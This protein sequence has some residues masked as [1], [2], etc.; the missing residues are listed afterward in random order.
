MEQHAEAAVHGLIEKDGRVLLLEKQTQD[1]DEVWT[2]PGGRA[3]IGEDPEEALVREVR[4]ETKLDISVGDPIGAYAFSWNGGTEGALAT[5]F[6]CALRGG[7]VDI[8]GNPADEPIV[9]S[10]W[11]EDIS[12][13]PMLPELRA[14]IGES[15]SN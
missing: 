13:V 3:R 8:S 14:I 12:T 7:T 6:D 15:A 11:V 5:V 10:A 4:E 2:L 9:G 1:V